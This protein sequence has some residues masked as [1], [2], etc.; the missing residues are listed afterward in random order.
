[1]AQLCSTKIVRAAMTTSAEPS[2]LST[3]QIDGPSSGSVPAFARARDDVAGE[4]GP[5]ACAADASAGAQPL[6]QCSQAL[7]RRALAATGYDVSDNGGRGSNRRC[8]GPAA[9]PV[10]TSRRADRGREE[11]P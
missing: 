1:M 3:S 8:G 7:A 5:S 4:A 6:V 10:L 11:P 2:A 9:R